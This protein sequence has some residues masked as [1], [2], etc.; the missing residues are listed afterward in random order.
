MSSQLNFRLTTS[1]KE[2]ANRIIDRLNKEKSLNKSDAFVYVFK[3]YEDNI[4]SNKSGEYI[5]PNV[6]D[7]LEQIKCGY[8]GFINDAFYC[9]E[10]M[11][12]KR[13]PTLLVGE[14]EVILKN[15]SA[16]IQYKLEQEINKRNTELRKESIKKLQSFMKGFI[17]ISK[18]GFRYTA[19]MCLCDADS[20]SI[21]FS[22]GGE[23]L[24]CPIL[25]KELVNIQLTCMKK[26]NPKTSKMPCEYLASLEGI[27]TLDPTIFKD[28][29]NIL[30]E[31]ALLPLRDNEL[32]EIKEQNDRLGINADF[33]VIDKEDEKFPD[34]TDGEY[35]CPDENEKNQS[36]INPKCPLSEKCDSYSPDKVWKR[37][38]LK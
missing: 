26:I 37:E 22:R 38:P 24:Q 4:I 13:E 23:A 28:M 27:Q 11:A 19:F 15:C 1:Q 8:I 6:R 3:Q 16:C 12:K 20:G 21:I 35:N 9:R 2:F 5:A 34:E 30:S 18:S 32:K 33:T 31:D 29:E 25:D 14:P 7:V 36:C 10:T 17:A